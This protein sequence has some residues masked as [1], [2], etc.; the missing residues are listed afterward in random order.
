MK[1]LLSVTSLVTT[2]FDGTENDEQHNIIVPIYIELE[3]PQT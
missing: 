2:N 1:I 3:R